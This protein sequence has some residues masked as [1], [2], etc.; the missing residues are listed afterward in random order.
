MEL[1]MALPLSLF[2]ALLITENYGYGYWMISRPVFAGPLIGL[3]MGDFPTGLF[4]GG[5]VEFDVH[6][7]F[8]HWWQRPS[9]CP[10]CWHSVNGIRYYKRWES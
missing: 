6:G 4:V 8:A 10:D 2:I 1:M 7:S 3:I 5:T 9:E